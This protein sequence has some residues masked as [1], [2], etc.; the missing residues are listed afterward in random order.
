MAVR[1]SGMAKG[2]RRTFASHLDTCWAQFFDLHG[3]LV[4]NAPE[5][6]RWVHHEPKRYPSLSHRV[7]GHTPTAVLTCINHVGSIPG[8]AWLFNVYFPTS[9][10][11]RE[12]EKRLAVMMRQGVP[13]ASDVSD[14]YS[15]AVWCII[16]LLQLCQAEPRPELWGKY[17]Y[18]LNRLQGCAGCRQPCCSTLLPQGSPA[19]APRLHHSSGDRH[20]GATC[21]SNHYR[22]EVCHLGGHHSHSTILW[23]QGPCW[24]CSG[25]HCVSKRQ[26]HHYFYIQEVQAS[27]GR[28]S[29]SSSQLMMSKAGAYHTADVVFL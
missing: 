28:G 6:S 20:S 9:G 21:E 14:T 12:H 24:H 26:E 3:Q 15:F 4:A 5:F 11:V 25:H 16:R 29:R 13:E 22:K 2:A 7:H 18:V 8:G 27:T 23:S 17:A 10:G 1:S 19:R